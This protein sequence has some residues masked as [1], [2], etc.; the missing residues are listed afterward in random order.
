MRAKWALLLKVQLLGLTGIGKL[1]RSADPKMRRRTV[2][3]LAAVGVVGL[4]VVFYAVLLAIGYCEQ[5]LGP[6]LPSFIAALTSLIVFAFSIFQ[7]GTILFSVKDRDFV[8]SLP[9]SRRAVIGAR[10]ACSYLTNLFFVL[11]VGLPVSVVYFAHEGITSA[12]F[13]TVALVL[14]TSPLL[15]LAV[16][17][18]LGTILSALTA[19]MRHKNLLQSILSVAFFV[20]VMAAS[21]SLSFSAGSAEEIDLSAMYDILV[22]SIYPPAVLVQWT[23]TGGKVWGVFAFAGLSLAAAAAFILIIGR[24]YDRIAARLSAHPSGRGYKRKEIRA[25]SAFG[26]LVAKEFRRLISCPGYFLNGISGSILM[27]LGAV[28]LLFADLSALEQAG[29]SLQS[30]APKL[31]SAAVGALIMLTGLS[32]PAASALSLEGNSRGLLFSMPVS[33]RKILLAKAAP[34]F[35]INCAAG[36][37]LAVVFCIRTAMPAAGWALCLVSVFLASPCVALAGIYFNAKF[38]KY[39]W[40]SE[41][42]VAKNSAPVMIVSFSA[43]L[44]GIAA[45][46]LGFLYGYPVAI[47]ADLLAAALAGLF[48]FLIRKVKLN[49]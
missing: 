38:P 22:G 5:G 31:A 23:L 33:A 41:T 7:G 14:L 47:V 24:F 18:A 37:L 21:F 1:R 8:L 49:V 36:T 16:G 45:A 4:I 34:T 9:L 40:T 43:M 10:L 3:F 30:D 46:G 2:G 17:A 27:V 26:A 44:L 35:L 48:F 11:L 28:F 12:S 32:C 39:D 29:I 13:F 19:G 42:Q 25:A 15:P 6:V 20:A